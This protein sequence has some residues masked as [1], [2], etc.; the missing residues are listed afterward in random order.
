MERDHRIRASGETVAVERERWK[1]VEELC[2]RYLGGRPSEI[3]LQLLKKAEAQRSEVRDFVE[4]AFRLMALSKFDARDLAPAVARFF[5]ILAPSILPGAWGGMVPPLTLPGRHRK[6]DAYLR[7]NQWAKF[8]A[9]TVLLDIGCG[10]PPQ[11]SIDAAEAFPEWQ[12]VGADPA[13][14]QY[15][16]YDERGNYASL[17]S[18]GSIRYFQAG[19][20]EEFLRLY[21]DRNATIQNFSEAYQQLLPILPAD[22][23]RLSTAEHGGMRLIRHPLSAYE[24]SNLKFVSGGFGSS[25]LPEAGIVRSFNVLLYFDA[26]FRRRTEEWVARI[27][28]PGGLFVCGRDDAAS[29]NAHYSVYRSEAG[30][31][32]EKEFAFGVETVRQSAWF[33]L[34]DGDRETLR[35]AEL[36]GILRSDRD[37]LRDYDSR[38]D[39]LLAENRIAVRDGNGC[40]AEPP[41]PIDPMRAL[42]VYEAIADVIEA[43]FAERGVTVLRR[44]G[45]NAWRNPVG[46]IAVGAF[47]E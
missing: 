10:F 37:F 40:L 32:V 31:L 19:R 16:L 35:L 2:D 4:R 6:I 25:D 47:Q 28:R 3:V 41:D 9:G 1:S 27:L 43:E 5:V 38:L 7:S 45:L 30:R 23:G 29:L 15:L 11:T 13:F 26:D 8:V 42:P 22:D 18:N 33:T 44:A 21:S 20:P 24:R 14:E 36:L 46:H 39:A 17:D 12:I 34:H